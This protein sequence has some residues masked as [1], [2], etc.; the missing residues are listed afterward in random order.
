MNE[1]NTTDECS[2]GE[3]FLSNLAQGSSANS[4]I[5]L[6]LKK[7][8]DGISELAISSNK[9]LSS[10]YDKRDLRE[11]FRAKCKSRLPFQDET[12]DRIYIE[13]YSDIT[14]AEKIPLLRECRRL[15]TMNGTVRI[16]I[17][18]KMTAEAVC[19]A[20]L[21][22]LIATPVIQNNDT[23]EGRSQNELLRYS[24]DATM[25][26]RRPDRRVPENPLVSILIPAYRATFFRETLKSAIEQ[27]YSN[28]EII[29][30][31]DSSNDEIKNIIV[32]HGGEDKNIRYLKNEPR[33][34]EV[35]N[36][37]KC[38]EL[39]RGYF[40]KYLNDDDVLDVTCVEKMVDVF[41]K[42]SSATLVTSRR[43]RIDS[44]G[45][46]M[47]DIPETARLIK[48]DAELEGLSTVRVLIRLCNIIGEPSTVMFRKADLAWVKPHFMA[49]G[50][51]I[52]YGLGDVAMWV[53]LLGQGNA[54]YIYE[55]LS[56]FRIHEGQSQWQPGTRAHRIESKA[57]YVTYGPLFGYNVGRRPISIKIKYYQSDNWTHIS[58][59][60]F[61]VSILL[62]LLKQKLSVFR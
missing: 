10:Q 18:Q 46:I 28:I 21:T 27:T 22:G 23:S 37:Y 43:K 49:F 40:I 31:D 14:M 2:N 1:L 20:H 36:V 32:K 16:L 9:Q 5:V 17:Q 33:L 48:Y 6:I 60:Y 13:N 61:N 59:V 45:R 26:F 52:A 53:H 34:G 12:V 41:R 54:Y 8:G 44:S 50:G 25:E 62:T 19:I 55:I 24:D 51:K 56:Y 58:L 15:L 4:D 42:H 57:R 30:C 7:I 11:V 39:A 38:F 47:R 29:I 35:S 3:M